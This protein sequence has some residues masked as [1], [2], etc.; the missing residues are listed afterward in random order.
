M[1]MNLHQG[2][3]FLN[4]KY[5]NIESDDD[6]ASE[7]Q[8]GT[9]DKSKELTQADDNDEYNEFKTSKEKTKEAIELFKHK[10]NY[11][12]EFAPFYNLKSI[13]KVYGDEDIRRK[14]NDIIETVQIGLR[15]VRS[16]QNKGTKL[17]KDRRSLKK[18]ERY[19]DILEAEAA[20]RFKDV[21][22]T[23]QAKKE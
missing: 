16:A 10:G 18:F 7:Q 22:E 17:K 19:L 8:E 2:V 23:K 1:K 15:S 3:S 21:A 20:G 5:Q 4:F 13:E 14:V 9:K 12:R 6:L 11:M